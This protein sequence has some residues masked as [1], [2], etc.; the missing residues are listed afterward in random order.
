MGKFINTNLLPLEVS[1]SPWLYENN[2]EDIKSVDTGKWMLFYNK[3][4]MNEAWFVAKKLYREHKLDGV[5]TM[6]CSTA[7]ENPRASQ[8]NEGIII[9]YCNDSSNEEI[10][11][12]IGKKIIEIFDYKERQIIYYKTDIQTHKGTFATG[13]KK[14]HTYKLFNALYK[15]KCLLSKNYLKIEE[16]HKYKMA[17]IIDVETT[18]FPQRGGLPY[19]QHPPFEMLTMYDSSRIVQISMMLCDDKFEQVE[20]KDFIVK[21]DGFTIGNSSF[22]GITNEMSE[23]Q[24]LPF[25]VIAKE[26]SEYL[27]QVSYVIAHNANF[28]LCI[29]KSELHRIGLNSIVDELNTKNVLCTMKH[30]KQIVKAR[31]KYGIK[32]P[33]LSELYSFVVNKDIEHAHNSKYDVINLH[34][35]VKTMYDSKKLNLHD[36]LIFS[37]K[38]EVNVVQEEPTDHTQEVVQTI[39]FS[40]LKLTELQKCCKENGIKGYSKMNKSTIIET[41]K[42]VTT[43]A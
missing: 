24:G 33:S 35:I 36:N 25:H 3:S 17:L 1:D 43:L 20:L 4:L 12:N 21:S 22:H 8:F 34:T 14:N 31:N 2:N 28:D 42:Q 16:M 40:K 32:D 23:T 37:P 6:K 13:S 5:E 9:L 15:G 39:D 27:K 18:G 10:I 30:T 38:M 41:L 7:Y 29:I 26:L 19:G 11:M